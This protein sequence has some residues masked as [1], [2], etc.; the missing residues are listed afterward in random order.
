MFA[1]SI[2][3]IMLV[4]SLAVDVGGVAIRRHRSVTLWAE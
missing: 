2:S 4:F 3:I 1:A